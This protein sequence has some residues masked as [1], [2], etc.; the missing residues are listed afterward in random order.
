MTDTIYCPRGGK[1]FD[2]AAARSGST[3]RYAQCWEDAE[4][5]LEGLA[6]RP[7]DTCLSIASAGDNTLALLAKDPARVIAVD[8]SPEQIAC[9]EVRVSAYRNLQH[10]E[11][12]QLLGSTPCENRDALYRRCRGDLSPSA[13]QFWDSR[14]DEIAAGIGNGG[15]FERYL[16]LFREWILPLVHGRAVVERLFAP[17]VATERHLFYTN[18]W[19]T[20]RWRLLFRVFFSRLVMSRIGREAA[21]FKYA[22]ASVAEELLDRTGAAMAGQ[23]GAANP[24]LQWICLGRHATA[25]PFALRAENFEVIR[26][27]LDRLEWHCGRLEDCIEQ[28]PA[29]AIDR[30]NLSDVFEYFSIPQYHQ[31]LVRLLRVA[32]PGARMMYWN[33]F[34]ERQR[35]QS[36]ANNLRSLVSLSENLHSRDKAFFYRAVIVEEVF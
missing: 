7:G 10:T 28:F 35:P 36:L 30:F 34:A 26:S 13:C 5:L 9:L 24:Y 20:W 17:R 2:R 31:V 18:V 4:V 33:L 32:R 3:V 23:D 19:N 25:L 11:L 8:Y 22:Q 16:R 21:F 29:N 15:K 12:L 6:I 1:V 27:R 14:P